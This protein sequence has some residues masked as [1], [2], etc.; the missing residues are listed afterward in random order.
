[1]GIR[2][3]VTMSIKM[4][5]HD[6][7][8]GRIGPYMQSKKNRV[9]RTSVGGREYVVKVFRDEWKERAQAEFSVLSWCREKGVPVPLP[10]TMVEDA[11]VMEPIEGE[12]AAVVFDELFSHSSGADLSEAQRE[13]AD[14]LAKWMSSFHIAF[15]FKL[16]RGDA[17]LKNFIITPSGITGLDFEEASSA[18]TLNDLGQLC[19][20][21]LMTDP[22][23]TAAKVSF[24]R[25]FTSCYWA[26]SGRN[27]TDGLAATV[28][29]AIRHYAPFRSNGSELLRYATRIENGELRVG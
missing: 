21:V 10:V 14:N 7:G 29:A 25:H 24:A 23:F 1:M 16:A 17:V 2:G 12:S 5:L 11:I 28:S 20:S 4:S 19:A 15:D 22:V 27:R 18:D 26:H 8:N 3:R 6:L 9:F 13:L